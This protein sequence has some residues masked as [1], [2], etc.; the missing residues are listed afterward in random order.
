MLTFFILMNATKAWLTLT[1]MERE[2]F[3]VAEV[4]PIFATSPS[5]RITFYDAEAFNGRCSDIAVF[6]SASID[7]YMVVVDA[8][9]N[10]KLYTIPYF[11]IIDIFP[12]KQANFI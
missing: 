12:A 5:V 9:R 1:P 2:Q 3:V 11:D 10:S 6:E 4:E 7:D 8:L